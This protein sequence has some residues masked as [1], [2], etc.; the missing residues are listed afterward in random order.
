M[1]GAAMRGPATWLVGV[2]AC[3]GLAGSAD[4]RELGVR[5]STPASSVAGAPCRVTVKVT[6]TVDATV[7]LQERA[8]RHW[9]TVARKRLKRRSVTLRCPVALA[10]RVR[11]FRALVRRGGKT[12]ASS[13]VAS[14]HVAPRPAPAPL[15]SAPAPAPP[16]PP[17][18]RPPID[19]AQ[20]GVEG[21]GGPPSPETL[22]L[23]ANSRVVFDAVGI[24]DLQAGRIDPRIVAVLTRLAGAHTITVTAMCSDYPKFTSG[25]TITRNYLGR[26]VEIGAIDGVAASAGNLTAR[27]VAVDLASFDTS[28][29][30][31]EVGSPFPIALPGYFTDAGTQDHLHI[32]FKQPIDPSW[33]PPAP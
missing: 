3:A 8:G 16:A 29:R 10:E 17:A 24:A 25:G 2:A 6:R 26:G 27:E 13:A 30:P 5:I 14:T 23:L 32:A 12:I 33:T 11:R 31:D 21:T 1:M 28:Y 15:P 18:T 19:P 4:A 20:F 9:R 22:A 7:L